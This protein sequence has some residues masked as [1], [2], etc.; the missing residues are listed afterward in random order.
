MVAIAL[1]ASAAGV[2]FAAQ[3]VGNTPGMAFVRVGA[4][5]NAELRFSAP[6][7]PL[8]RIGGF[9]DTLEVRVCRGWRRAGVRRGSCARTAVR[10]RGGTA[11][12]SIGQGT[13]CSRSLDGPRRGNSFLRGFRIGGRSEGSAGDPAEYRSALLADGDA[14]R[15]RCG[16]VTVDRTRV[17]NRWSDDGGRRRDSRGRG[18]HDLISRAGRACPSYEIPNPHAADDR[19][20]GSSHKLPCSKRL[21]ACHEKRPFVQTPAGRLLWGYYTT[22]RA[23]LSS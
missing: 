18:L 22:C 1:A 15:P 6:F 19:H 13:L 9:I 8:F 12:V 17:L 7:L 4:G 16:V 23:F 3:L 11:G 20:R 2:P 14:R 21:T 5:L 10:S